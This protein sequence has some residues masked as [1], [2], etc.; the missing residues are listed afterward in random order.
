M[1]EPFVTVELL[2]AVNCK[3]LSINNRR[4]SQTK[5]YGLMDVI[6]EFEVSTGDILDAIDIRPAP[7]IEAEPV[8]HGRWETIEDYDGDC[9]YRCS[10]CGE[11]WT[12]IAGTPKDNN[13]NYCPRC[14][15]KMD[16]GAENG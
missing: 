16:G 11:E 5:G 2:R 12:L 14:G 7:T 1:A 4:V 6:A 8:R 3:V 15:A 9:I 13:M 10:V